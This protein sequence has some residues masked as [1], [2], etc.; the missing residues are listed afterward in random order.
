MKFVFTLVLSISIAMVIPNNIPSDN[1]VS[2]TGTER[3]DNSRPLDNIETNP[4][5]ED[6]LF[7]V[8]VDSGANWSGRTDDERIYTGTDDLF[9]ELEGTLQSIELGDGIWSGVPLNEGNGWVANTARHRAT[10]RNPEINLGGES[11]L[12]P[13][14]SSDYKKDNLSD[15]YDL[16]DESYDS[17]FDAI[18]LNVTGSTEEEEEDNISTVSIAPELANSSSRF[19]GIG[20]RFQTF[21]HNSQAAAN[22]AKESTKLAASQAKLVAQERAIRAKQTTQVAALRAKQSALET[23]LKAKEASLAAATRLYGQGKEAAQNLNLG[24]TL[25]TARY[26]WQSRTPKP[27]NNPEFNYPNNEDSEV[28]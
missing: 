19:H 9:N 2:A 11:V 1:S 22:R 27:E 15:G 8:S 14:D 18:P 26:S 23:A 24:R 7:S 10:N 17:G 4:F 13:D 25:N 16:D 5:R 20:E 3:V 12:S 6:D 21:G 28:I